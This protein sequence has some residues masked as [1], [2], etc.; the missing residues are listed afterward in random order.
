MD[1]DFMS[2]DLSENVFGYSRSMDN[3]IFFMLINTGN[4]REIINMNN[5]RTSLRN[6]SKIVLVSSF[7]VYK[8]G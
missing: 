7:S 3:E 5:L 6:E 1:G 8:V 4:K 2:K